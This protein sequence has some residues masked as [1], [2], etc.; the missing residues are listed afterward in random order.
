[1][2]DNN[3]DGPDGLADPFYYDDSISQRAMAFYY[4]AKLSDTVQDKATKE[5]CLTMLRKLNGS[6]KAPSTAEL[7]AIDGGSQLTGP[8]NR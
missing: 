1:M 7:H 4:V 2:S 6:I 3:N 8:N 5:L